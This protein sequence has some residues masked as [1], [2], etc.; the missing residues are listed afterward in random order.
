MDVLEKQKFLKLKY[1]KPKGLEAQILQMD[2]DCST[3]WATDIFHLVFNTDSHD[4]IF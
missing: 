4:I 1:M 3:I 2:D